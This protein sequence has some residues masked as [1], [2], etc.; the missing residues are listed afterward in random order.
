MW[1]QILMMRFTRMSAKSWKISPERPSDNTECQVSRLMEST[2]FS[3]SENAIPVPS[4][5]ACSTIT[6]GT[7]PLPFPWLVCLRW[8]G[9]WCSPLCPWYTAGCSEAALRHRR[10]RRPPP[11]TCCPPLSQRGSPRAA[12][13]AT[14]SPATLTWRHTSELD[15]TKVTH[16]H[17]SSASSH[18]CTRGCFSFPICRFALFCLHRDSTCQHTSTFSHPSI[19]PPSQGFFYQLTFNPPLSLS[20]SCGLVTVFVWRGME[21]SALA[22]CCLGGVKKAQSDV[23]KVDK[24][25]VGSWWYGEILNQRERVSKIF[26]CFNPADLAFLML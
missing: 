19:A 23:G 26:S 1:W 21:K 12:P 3:V 17:T 24:H 14:C 5:Q 15:A 18:I 16:A 20:D 4:A 7:T 11:P 6:L 22:W 2:K 25:K 13:T 8:W 10:R 9:A